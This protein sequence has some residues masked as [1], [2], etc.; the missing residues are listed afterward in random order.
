MKIVIAA[1]AALSLSISNTFAVSHDDAFQKV[2]RDYVEKYLR[3]N[4]EQATELGDH[5]FDGE[6]TDYSAEARSRDLATQK[7][8]R[9][10][11][12]TIDRSQLIAANNIDFRILKKNIDSQ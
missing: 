11:L 2:A 9:D 12:D 8:F 1:A 10:K 4:P 5:R 7:D 6:L 3:A